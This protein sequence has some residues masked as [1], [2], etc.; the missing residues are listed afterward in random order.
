[1][2][3]RLLKAA[4]SLVLLTSWFTAPV[5]VQEKFAGDA[6]A[7]DLVPN[8]SLPY[9]KTGYVWGSVTGFRRSRRIASSSSCAA[10]SRCRRRS[11][12]T[13][14]ASTVVRAQRDRRARQRNEE[15]H[16]R[17]RCRRTAAGN[18]DAVGRAVSR[19][20]QGTHQPVQSR[21]AGMGGQRAPQSGPRVS[22]DGKQL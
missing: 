1:M 4:V 11:R 12:R 9:P 5:A 6:G 18:L 7:Y 10:R 21:A 22:N 13:S 17:A 8:W 14:A 20:S 2:N 19:R 15:L 3:R 16:L